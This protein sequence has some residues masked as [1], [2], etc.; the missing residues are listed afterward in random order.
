MSARYT[1]SKSEAQRHTEI[2]KGMLKKPE[3]K[4]R[5]SRIEVQQLPT[6]IRSLLHCIILNPSRRA[7]DTRRVEQLCADCKRNGEWN[8]CGTM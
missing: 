5:A 3:N 8:S 4:V 6:R 7:D 2:L 1:Q